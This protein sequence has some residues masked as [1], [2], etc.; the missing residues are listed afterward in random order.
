MAA[1]RPVGSTAV[2]SGV[3][4]RAL[5][6]AGLLLGGKTASGIMQLATLALAARSLGLESFGL[7]SVILAQVQLLV[8]L[9]T[10]QSNQGIV[11]YGVRHMNSGD[12]TA[13]QGLVKFGLLLDLCAALVAATAAFF[14]APIIA[15]NAGWGPD[16]VKAAQL[17]A[18]LPLASAIATPKG[19][20]RLFGRFDLLAQQVAVTPFARLIGVAVLSLTGGSL[21]AY[22]AVWLVSGFL[23]VAVALGLAWR[24]ARRQD[25]LSGLTFSLSGSVSANP[26]IWRF[27]ILSNLQSSFALLPAQLST[28]LVGL[29]LGAPAAGLVRVAQEIGT[30]LAKPIDLINQTVYPDTARLVEAGAFARLRTLIARSGMTAVAIG[31][32]TT[33]LLYFVGQQIIRLIFGPDYDSSFTLLILIS[34]AT[35]LKVS[36]FAAE[37]ALYALGRPGRL[38]VIAILANI[39][40][41]AVLFATV[42]E[43]GLLAAGAAH[44]A[45]AAVTAIASLIFLAAILP[46]DDQ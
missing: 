16:Y 2:T 11:R 21:L 18:I 32:G 6:N 39:V 14:I 8:A 44:I 7:F 19:L 28:L 38:L 23:G 40:F 1:E 20:L 46:R 9:S 33:V 10:F 24:E 5:H 43:F 34:I 22:S 13:F 15:R 25:Q 27:S 41:V 17:L 35:A 42:G 26:G 37:P 4:R 45:A 29:L 36:L 30:A 12:R 3:L 31:A